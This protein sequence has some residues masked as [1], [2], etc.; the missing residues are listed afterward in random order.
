VSR[1]RRGTAPAEFARDREA[2]IA[3]ID[4]F[5]ALPAGAPRARHSLFGVL[6]P[7]ERARW[8]WAHVDLHLRPFGA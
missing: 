7:N 1:H 2:V 8:A 6:A 3:L 5:L 4:R